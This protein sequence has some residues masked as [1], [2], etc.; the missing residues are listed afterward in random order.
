MGE[1]QLK[2][3]PWNGASISIQRQTVAKG[4]GLVTELKKI[5]LRIFHEQ[6]C[7]RNEG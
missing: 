3:W 4:E 5:I 2:H 6:N 1:N 7:Q